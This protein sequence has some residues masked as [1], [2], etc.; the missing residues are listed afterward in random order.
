MY[1]NPVSIKRAV[2][3]MSVSRHLERVGDLAT[4]IAEEV[5]YMVDGDIIRHAAEEYTDVE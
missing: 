3:L 5:V 2:H 4:N 1:K